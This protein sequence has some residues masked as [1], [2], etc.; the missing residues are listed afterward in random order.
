MTLPQTGFMK[1]KTPGTALQV[2]AWK[3]IVH[4][5][6]GRGDR[7]EVGEGLGMCGAARRVVGEDA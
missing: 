4:E 7:G 6:P 2:E 1:C 3:W 5:K